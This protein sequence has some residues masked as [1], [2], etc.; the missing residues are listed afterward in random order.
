MST[1]AKE[2]TAPVT[3]ICSC[4]VCGET[5]SAKSRFRPGH[6]AKLV[7]VA[8]G[9]V[10]GVNTANPRRRAVVQLPADHPLHRF[11]SGINQDDLQQVID[12]ATE[13]AAGL[14][15]PALAAKFARACMNLWARESKAAERAAEAAA[16]GDAADC[17]ID[18]D[19]GDEEAAKPATKIAKASKTSGVPEAATGTDEK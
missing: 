10:V 16:K 11:G 4:G 13:E 15:G 17:A 19:A 3:R 1:P 9:W 8:A 12:H 6:D 5:V 2:T 7:S 14:Y 18:A